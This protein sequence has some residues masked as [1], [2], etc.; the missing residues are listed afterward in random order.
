VDKKSNETSFD[1]IRKIKKILRPKKIGHAGTLDFFAT[2]LLIILIN[3]GTKLFN[4]IMSENKLYIATIFFGIETNTF[5]CTGEVIM[6]RD[7]P[8]MD[9]DYIK[10]KL[11]NFIG[12]IEQKP[13]A[14][15]ALKYKGVRAYKLARRGIQVELKKRYVN[16]Y[17][18]KLISWIPP[19]L[20]IEIK[21]SSGTYIRSLAVD[22]AKA[23]GTCGH[24]KALRRISCGSFH[25]SDAISLE[26]KISKDLLEKRIISLT[27]ALP[28]FK[29]IYVDDSMAWKIRNGVQPKLKYVDMKKGYIKFVR[30]NKLIAIAKV[31]ETGRVMLERVFH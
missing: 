16:I 29:T 11:K 25:V 31:E 6:K 3:Q 23:F 24:L 10:E 15:S 22:I 9:E 2:G 5:D 19:E 27:D 28:Q 4:F 14:F 20:T 26:N 17:D 8:D 7:V 30:D 18:I 13:P 1:V 12:I 21:C